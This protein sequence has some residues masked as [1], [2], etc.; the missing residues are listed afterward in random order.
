MCRTSFPKTTSRRSRAS[1][2]LREKKK[3]PK[4]IRIRV[5]FLIRKLRLCPTT[6]QLTQRRKKR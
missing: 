3:I 2:I 1:K 5:L 4:G 6:Q